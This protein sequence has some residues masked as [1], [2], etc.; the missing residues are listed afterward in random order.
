M[1]YVGQMDSYKTGILDETNKHVKN[2]EG[3]VTY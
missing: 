2:T 1:W 3:I